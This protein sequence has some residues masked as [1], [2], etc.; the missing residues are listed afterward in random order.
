MSTHLEVT[1]EDLDNRSQ[2]LSTV[3]MEYQRLK[4]RMD[5]EKG[6]T[7][8]VRIKKEEQNLRKE[9][10][11]L[12]EEQEVTTNRME[13]LHRQEYKLKDELVQLN[14][15][16]QLKVEELHSTEQNILKCQTGIYR[17]QRRKKHTLAG[18]EGPPLS[19]KE[20]SAAGIAW[21]AHPLQL[22]FNR[23]TRTFFQFQEEKAECEVKVESV[24]EFAKRHILKQQERWDQEGNEIL[25]R[26]K[27]VRNLFLMNLE[28]IRF[29][30][31]ACQN[32]KG[33]FKIKKLR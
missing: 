11:H 30:R 4:T 5:L 6:K 23:L 27:I 19:N 9:I 21:M 14:R 2:E 24:V 22:K 3:D 28:D 31:N 26:T 18:L 12:K 29:R 17:P 16:L 13:K 8:H 15:A 7:F 20:D 25:K 32:A 10:E 33:E 1:L